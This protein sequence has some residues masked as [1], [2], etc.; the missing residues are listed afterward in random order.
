MANRRLQ[1]EIEKTL[2]KVDEGVLVFEQIWDKVYSAATTSQKEKYESDLKKEI[3]KLQRLRDSIKTWQG[4]S[5]IKDKTKLDSARKLIE[6][7]ME[8]FK[9]CEKET[10]TKAYSKEGLALDRTDPKERAKGEVREWIAEAMKRLRDQCDEFEAEIE[11]LSGTGKKGKKLQGGGRIDDLRYHTERHNYHITMLERILRAVDNETVSCDEANDLKGSVDFYIEANQEPDFY[12]DEEMYDALDLDAPAPAAGGS[13][14]EGSTPSQEPEILSKEMEKKLSTKSPSPQPS[15]SPTKKNKTPSLG[16]QPVPS[17]SPGKTVI[18]PSLTTPATKSPPRSNKVGPIASTK[19]EAETAQPMTKVIA[20]PQPSPI[21]PNMG[22]RQPLLSNI[23]KGTSASSSVVTQATMPAKVVGQ[24]PPGSPQNLQDA[25][26]VTGEKKEMGP[27]GVA[28]SVDQPV[29]LPPGERLSDPHGLLHPFGMS[30]G[31][32]KMPTL[33]AIKTMSSESLHDADRRAPPEQAVPAD[34]RQGREATGPVTPEDLERQLNVLSRAMQMMPE[35]V[36][37]EAS[38]SSTRPYKPRNPAQV[39]PSFPTVPS[40]VFEN[41]AIFKK[42]AEDTW[43]FIFY[44]QQGTYQQYCAAKELKNKSWRF[45]KKFLRWFSRHTE[46]EIT[47]E[48]YEQG[49]YLY[50]DYLLTEDSKTGWCQKIKNDFRF[51]YMYLEDELK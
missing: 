14:R 44:Y 5:N 35:S 41:P 21:T 28:R 20:A 36:E 38:K 7:K 18:Q 46:P 9:I 33:S 26:V 32:G 2:K 43:F 25:K 27:L 23:V 49:S 51:D 47:T 37:T 50:F 4:D 1:T 42:F 31:A 29:A 34:V 48:E 30:G 11:S 16:A 6:E 22:G 40:H 8:K 39:P 13:G 15:S 24:M 45:H 10:K 3:K 17:G 12:E 19:P